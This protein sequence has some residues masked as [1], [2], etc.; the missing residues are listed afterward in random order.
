MLAMKRP[1]CRSSCVPWK[2]PSVRLRPTPA[3]TVRVIVENI[4]NAKTSPAMASTLCKNEYV[5]MIEARYHR[6][7][8][9][10]P[11]RAAECGQRGGHG[12]DHRVPGCG[13]SRSRTRGSCRWRWA[14]WAACIKPSAGAEKFK[15]EEA[16]SRCKVTA[17][18]PFF[19]ASAHAPCI[20]KHY[21]RRRIQRRSHSTARIKA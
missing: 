11:F 7:Y 2:S 18:A 6:S 17:A 10:Y 1:V 5:D 21:R 4:K 3:S 12:A 16:L 9:G 8:Q 13:Y 15:I 14:A 20:G 19:Y